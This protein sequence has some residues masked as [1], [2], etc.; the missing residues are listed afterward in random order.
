MVVNRRTK[1]SKVILSGGLV[2]FFCLGWFSSVFAATT[3]IKGK[4]VDEHS[5]KGIV[6]TSIKIYD[7]KG[8][9]IV[10][11]KVDN[12]A[13]EYYIEGDFSVFN[14]YFIYVSSEGYKEVQ[15]TK[16]FPRR[17]TYV[18]NFPLRSLK[19][20]AK[21]NTAPKIISLIPQD[22]SRFIVGDRFE[23]SVEA[24]DAEEDRLE[25]RYLLDGKVLQNWGV[26]PIYQTLYSS[27]NRG[28]HRITV[29]VRDN[30]GG[31]TGQAVEIYIFDKFPLPPDI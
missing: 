13:G 28:R 30:K 2:L 9:T 15:L 18:I 17:Q 26:E 11:E 20:K 27:D 12:A 8:R 31:L 25:Y 23:I 7:I 14:L 19:Y 6:G 21:I 29:Q 16:Y 24:D 4:V 1:P 3:I 10:S 5:N 22:K